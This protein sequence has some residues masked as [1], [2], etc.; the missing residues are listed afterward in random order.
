MA[1]GAAFAALRV[2]VATLP[3]SRAARYSSEKKVRRFGARLSWEEHKAAFTE[4]EFK[5]AYR[6]TKQGFGILLEKI[7]DDVR[8]GNPTQA[9]RSSSG[10]VTPEIRLSMTLRYLSGG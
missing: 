6:V 10:E 8:T 2:I 9:E 1:R 7:R 4:A 3:P 5:T